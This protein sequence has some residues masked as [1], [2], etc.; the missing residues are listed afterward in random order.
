MY[1]ASQRELARGSRRSVIASVLLDKNGCPLEQDLS[2]TISSFAWGLPIA[3]Q[4]NLDQLASWPEQEKLLIKI[5]KERL[6]KKNEKDEIIPL[7]TLRIRKVYDRLVEKLQLTGHDIKPPYFAI[8]HYQ[9]F[10][11]KNLPETSVL[12]S[13]FLSDLCSAGQLVKY[14]RLPHA[15]S[16]YLGVNTPHLKTDLLVNQDGLRHLLQPALTPLGRWPSKGRFSLSLLQQAVVN[17]TS[18]EGLKETGVLGV[19]GPPGTGKTTLLRDI[20]AARIV[21]RARVMVE[22]DDPNNAFTSSKQSLK[23]KGAMLTLHRLDS[24]LKGFEIV[25]ASSNNKAVQNISAE[26]PGLNAIAADATELRYFK[27]ISDR[28]LQRESWGMIAAVLGNASNRYEF[29]KA[30][31][32]DDE[33]GFSTYL[34]HVAGIPQTVLEPQTQKSEL[35]RKRLRMVVDAERP[36][37]NHGEALLNWQKAR[38]SFAKELK[39]SRITQK[40]LQIIHEKLLLIMPLSSEIAKVKKEVLILERVL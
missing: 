26:L 37:R 30:F 4:G 25:V 22:Y 2:I 5:L 33:Y 12:N 34:N 40:K 31:W 7:T 6:I 32:R 3:L 13:F 19:N 1:P 14:N 39:N 36:P 38:I 29:A 15:L 21:E 28:V 10:A 20:V 23:R 24:R 8:R 9:Y 11:S 35:P 27:S 17:S 18:R 16:F